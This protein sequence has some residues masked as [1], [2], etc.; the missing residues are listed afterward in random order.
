LNTD[1]RALPKIPEGQTTELWDAVLR[2]V[3]FLFKVALLISL[4]I[5]L[6]SF[7]VSNQYRSTATLLPEDLQAASSA[8]AALS[9]V[10]N[11]L[12]A[13]PGGYEKLYPTM[14]GSETVL[15]DIIYRRRRIEGFSGPVDLIGFWKIEESTSLE[16]YERALKRL[17]RD[18]DISIDNKTDI[19]TVSLATA[20]AALSAQIVQEIIIGTDAFL[21]HQHRT[22]ASEQGRWIDSR[23]SRVQADL[24]GAEDSLRIFRQVN[25][26][27]ASPSLVL[28]ESRLVRQVDLNSALFLELSRQRELTKIDEIKNVPVLNVLDSARVSAIIDSPNRPIIGILSFMLS[29]LGGLAFIAVRLS[30]PREVS[31]TAAWVRDVSG[32]VLAFVRFRR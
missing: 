5:T 31:A 15:R 17:R 10:A 3:G 7:L 32:R 1:L 13:S 23:L 24:R 6:V 19:V 14:V 2:S 25:R 11:L 16:Q 8:F 18:L 27:V 9:N 29:F 4:P 12:G 28:A 20:D 30:Y 26:V 21:R 22:Y